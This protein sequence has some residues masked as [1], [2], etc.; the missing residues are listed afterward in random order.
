MLSL[1][2]LTALTM[3]N[4][5]G[6]K[7]GGMDIVHKEEYNAKDYFDRRPEVELALPTMDVDSN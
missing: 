6:L 7:L 4:T 5:E 1:N 3:C 2:L